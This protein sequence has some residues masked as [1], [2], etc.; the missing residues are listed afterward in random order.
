MKVHYGLGAGET[1]CGVPSLGNR[2]TT[3][4]REVTCDP[5]LAALVRVEPM[6]LLNLQQRRVLAKL[7]QCKKRGDSM[8]IVHLPGVDVN[9]SK[10][11][12]DGRVPGEQ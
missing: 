1:Q 2:V 11:T 6:A 8:F 4:A 10:V 12:P 9:F 5:C 3:I 7:D